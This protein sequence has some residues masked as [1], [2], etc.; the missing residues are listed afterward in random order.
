M[1]KEPP[2]GRDAFQTLRLMML[3]GL[4]TL[5]A[6]TVVMSATGSVPILPNEDTML[7][8][9]GPVTAVAALPILGMLTLSPTWIDRRSC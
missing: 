4:M 7:T 1:T 5:S 6:V 9:I 3:M 8:G 2:S